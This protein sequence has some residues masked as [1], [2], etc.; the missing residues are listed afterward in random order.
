MVRHDGRCPDTLNT[1]IRSPDRVTGATARLGR[2]RVR[3]DVAT[4]RSSV[5]VVHGL[6]D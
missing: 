3:D 4:I 5:F 2:A 1:L 6:N